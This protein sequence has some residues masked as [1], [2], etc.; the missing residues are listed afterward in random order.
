MTATLSALA[1]ALSLG[2]APA[3]SPAS[4]PGN[5]LPPMPASLSTRAAAVEAVE[6]QL[7]AAE[8]SL[9]FVEAQMGGVALDLR[10]QRALA[11]THTGFH[12]VGPMTQGLGWE[13]YPAAAPLDRLLA[14]NTSDMALKPNPAAAL[15]PPRAPSPDVLLNKTGSTNGFGAYAAFIPRRKVGVVLLANRNY[16]NADR[17]RLAHGILQAVP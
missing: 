11:F 6:A 16:P 4:K 14:G 3:P 12:D 10:L 15:V 7:H 8:Q 13:M 5:A 9:R 2:A 17:V 1:L